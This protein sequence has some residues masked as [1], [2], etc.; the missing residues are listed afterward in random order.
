M[1]EVLIQV[2]KKNQQYVQQSKG[3][4]VMG[5]LVDKTSVNLTQA[6][7]NYV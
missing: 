4:L 3:T 6:Q 5:L 2:L 7:L 1:L